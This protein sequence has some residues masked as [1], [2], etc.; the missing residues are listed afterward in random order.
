MSTS[1]SVF[2]YCHLLG[3]GRAN[4]DVVKLIN[5]RDISTETGTNKLQFHFQLNYDSRC[6][7]IEVR[8]LKALL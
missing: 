8:N 7:V 5:F 3:D 4:W 1:H 2:H 6:N